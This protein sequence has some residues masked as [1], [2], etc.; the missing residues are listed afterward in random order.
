VDPTALFPQVGHFQ[1]VRIEAGRDQHLPEGRLMQP[2]RAG[3]H[4]DAIQAVLRNIVADLA[5][6]G[7]AARITDG[8]GDGHIRQTGNGCGDPVAIHR[9]RNVHAAAAYIDADAKIR[10]RR[11]I[12]LGCC[13]VHG[14]GRGHDAFLS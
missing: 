4:H 10:L 11:C 2:R 1:Q 5:L 6:P 7:L 14:C 9:L 13:C 12:S 8:L 3:A